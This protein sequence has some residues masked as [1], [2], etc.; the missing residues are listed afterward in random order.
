MITGNTR[1][2][3]VLG[4][5]VSQ[6]L[7]P[8]MHNAAMRVLGLDAV[9]V[10]LPSADA[11]VEPLI[12]ALT[13]AGGGGSVT[14]PHKLRAAASV[15]R[16]TELVRIL[17]ACNT[18][19]REDGT[20]AG[21]NTDVA[22][23]LHAVKIVGGGRVWAIAGTGASARAAVEAA[24]TIGVG[25]AVR[26]RSESRAA[27]LIEWAGSRGVEVA[28]LPDADLLINATLLGWQG[29]DP[30]PFDGAELPRARAAVDMVY[31]PGETAWIRA[32]RERGLAAVDGREML[33][34]QGVAAFRR[35]FPR[36]EP[37]MEVMRAAVERALRGPG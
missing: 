29:D 6:S 31:R 18:F 21:D 16:P 1:V 23:V 36:H 32:A 20:S 37:P 2:F 4:A 11:A 26:S 25:V 35:W 24:R 10:A 27:S 34:G 28:T 14:R 30:M 5:P 22:G 13:A 19:W 33:L 3:A 7:S 15:S 12:A 8:V 17:D 9:Y